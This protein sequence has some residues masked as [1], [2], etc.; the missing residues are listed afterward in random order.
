MKEFNP[1]KLVEMMKAN[2]DWDDEM[3][4]PNNFD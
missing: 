2:G 4:D 1:E 3:G